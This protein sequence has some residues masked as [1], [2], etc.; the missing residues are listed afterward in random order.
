MSWGYKITILYVGFVL[1]VLTMVTLSVRQKVDLESADY[2]EQE[3]KFQDKIDKMQRTDALQ[4][5]LK[6][7]VQP[8]GILLRFPAQFDGQAVSGSIY[9]LR[10]SDQGLDKT[11]AVPATTTGIQRVSTESLRKGLYRMKLSWHVGSTEYYNE[12]I[13]QVN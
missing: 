13:I 6:W 5:Q 12:G 7:E 11:I 4:T 10:P 2:Y 8:G 9:F 3:L 1:L